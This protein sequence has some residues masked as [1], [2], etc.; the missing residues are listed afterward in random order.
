MSD[1]PS[2]VVPGLGST[3]GRIVV[4]E[5]RKLAVSRLA[6]AGWI[7]LVGLTGLTMLL[8]VLAVDSVA[9]AMG[10][11]PK[12]PEAL[13][14]TLQ[15]RNFYF[16]QAWLLVLGAVSLAGEYRS[17]TLREDLARAVPRWGVLAAKVVAL[18]TFSATTLIA[19][20][21]LCTAI[22]ATRL[23][24]GGGAEWGPWFAGLAGTVVTDTSFVIA[25]LLFALLA[26]R[27]ANTLIVALL[28]VGME[29]AFAN[30]LWIISG[31]DPSMLD[32]IAPGVPLG[33]MAGAVWPYLPSAVW[34]IGTTLAIQNPV[35]AVSWIALFGWTA[36]LGAIA[37]VRFERLDVP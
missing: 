11:E 26:R 28:F 33:P 7:F 31:L 4:A 8:A 17:R 21:L 22:A 25:V 3:L 18:T 20:S 15:L 5:L 27:V 12:V 9:P 6:W 13:V 30:G 1:V 19:Q 35:D 29:S 23:S 14:F 37:V 36:L 16:A 2:L 34:G 24:F 10:Q 32:A